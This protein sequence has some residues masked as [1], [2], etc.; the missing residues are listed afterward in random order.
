VSL[1]KMLAATGA[2]NESVKGVYSSKHCEKMSEMADAVGSYR[3]A[4][5]P[6]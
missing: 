3:H 4:V 5:Y 6:E 1:G 2:S